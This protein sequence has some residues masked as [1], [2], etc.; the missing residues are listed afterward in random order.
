MKTLTTLTKKSLSI[1]M[2]RVKK[3]EALELV[4]VKTEK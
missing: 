4:L 1:Q 2:K 3:K